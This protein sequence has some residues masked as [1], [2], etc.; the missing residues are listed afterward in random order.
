[1]ASLFLPSGGKSGGGIRL[2][3]IH[4]KGEGGRGGGG[5][6]E[7]G[8][9]W[10]FC[11][12]HLPP[13]LHAKRKKP[14]HNFNMLCFSVVTTSPNSSTFWCSVTNT[15]KHQQGT[16]KSPSCPLPHTSWFATSAGR[17]RCLQGG[18]GWGGS[19]QCPALRAPA[20]RRHRHFPL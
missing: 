20:E 14:Y 3:A 10:N 6:G 8:E 1:M 9:V 12:Y 13:P 2:S 16:K 5:G 7:G 4:I 17:W 15:L 11:G 19:R 18:G